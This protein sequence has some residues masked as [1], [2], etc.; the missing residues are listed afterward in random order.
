MG[1]A[2]KKTIKSLSDQGLSELFLSRDEFS[3]KEISLIEQEARNR[4]FSNK[5]FNG[6]DDEY[7][8]FGNVSKSKGFI[9]WFVTLVSYAA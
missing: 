2:F 1:I 6:D 9:S 5:D 7:L 8:G 3:G 4:F